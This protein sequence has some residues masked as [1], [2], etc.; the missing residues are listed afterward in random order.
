[1]VQVEGRVWKFGDHVSSDLIVPTSTLM[2]SESERGFAEKPLA[3]LRPE[4]PREVQEGD[5]IV[6]GQNFACGSI[7]PLTPLLELGI[8]GVIAESFGPTFL[9]QCAYEGVPGVTAAGLT[10]Q[11]N[12][13]DQVRIEVRKDGNRIINLTTGWEATRPPFPDLIREA[14]ES[15]GLHKKLGMAAAG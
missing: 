15:G 2:R 10:D 3:I 7:R 1:M 13:G 5:L 6:A 4:F 8:R 9:R 12:D 11:L 14:F